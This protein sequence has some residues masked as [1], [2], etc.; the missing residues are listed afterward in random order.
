[1]KLVDALKEYKGLWVSSPNLPV[2]YRIK[3]GT[4]EEEESVPEVLLHDDLY[5]FGTLHLEDLEDENWDLDCVRLE[6]ITSTKSGVLSLASVL[7]A[8]ATGCRVWVDGWE[9]YLH[10]PANY[11]YYFNADGSVMERDSQNGIIPQQKLYMLVQNPEQLPYRAEEHLA[12]PYI[13]SPDNASA[14]LPSLR[15]SPK[16]LG[17][18]RPRRY[19]LP[20]VSSLLTDFVGT[21]EAVHPITTSALPFGT[22]AKDKLLENEERRKKDER[23]EARRKKRAADK[24][25]KSLKAGEGALSK[26]YYA[27]A[28]KQPTKKVAKKK[29]KKK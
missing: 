16:K 9:G 1:M 20:G 29:G 5:Q 19:L 21:P 27:T 15:K 13:V 2:K 23:N 14:A 4:D 12:P 6:D 10:K 17:P 28:T 3:A 24:M 25:L 8:L 7:L 11:L 26:R 18:R 22:P